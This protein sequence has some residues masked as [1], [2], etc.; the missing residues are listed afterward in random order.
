MTIN[1]PAG[2][3][4]LRSKLPAYA[5]SLLSLRMAGLDPLYAMLVFSKDWAL[6]KDYAERARAAR[7]R[8]LAA[9]SPEWVKA[10]GWPV[11]A[12]SPRDYAPGVYD[13]R[14][15]A[16][17]CVTVKDIDLGW[18]DV[19]GPQGRR[20]RWGP[21]YFLLGDLA[22]W[23]GYVK[24]ELPDV[25]TTYSAS[26]LAFCECSGNPETRRYDQWPAWWSQTL[27]E[28]HGQRSHQW[29]TDLAR[30]SEQHSARAA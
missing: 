3:P 24:V 13:F 10:A 15:F 4:R 6:A 25:P 21:L 1:I 30:F 12:L 19:E 17:V 23:A 2:N 20:T 18:H 16:G 27:E 28:G 8:K 29:F 14:V 5:H 9:F 11:V 7:Q 26:L 22:Q